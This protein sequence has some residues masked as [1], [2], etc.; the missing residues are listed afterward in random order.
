MPH[1]S[2]RVGVCNEP[3]CPNSTLPGRRKC[4]DHDPGRWATKT[5]GFPRGVRLARLRAHPVCECQGAASYCTHE[6]PCSAPSQQVDHHQ[7][8]SVGGT[9]DP[10]NAR[11]LC[12]PCHDTKTVRERNE[13]RRRRA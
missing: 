13:H 4:P 7:A 12:R 5:N 3:R 1:P 8:V 11:A 2:R 6:E 10:S 9:D